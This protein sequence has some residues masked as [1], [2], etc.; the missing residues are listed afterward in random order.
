MKKNCKT[1]FFRFN[2]E[3]YFVSRNEASVWQFN[4]QS[5]S[6]R[7]VLQSNQAAT[8]CLRP[9]YRSVTVSLFYRLHHRTAVWIMIKLARPTTRSSHVCRHPARPPDHLPV[10]YYLADA[11]LSA[12]PSVVRPLAWQLQR[13][14]L[15]AAPLPVARTVGLASTSAFNQESRSKLISFGFNLACG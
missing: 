7:S 4:R 11:A 9:S 3:I 13:L 2:M 8:V 14:S 15:F 5:I 12:S 6:A 10:S 1:P